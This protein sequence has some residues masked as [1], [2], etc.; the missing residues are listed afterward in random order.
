MIPEDELLE[1]LTAVGAFVFVNW[2][3]MYPFTASSGLFPNLSRTLPDRY[4]SADAS[5]TV[6]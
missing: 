4:Q 3:T 5:L 6:L 2:H 1:V